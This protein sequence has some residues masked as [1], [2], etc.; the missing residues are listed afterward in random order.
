MKYSRKILKVSSNIKLEEASY[1]IKEISLKSNKQQQHD[2]NIEV[3]VIGELKQ[4]S[5]GHF[6]EVTI[7]WTC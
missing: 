3:S 4:Y 7:N 2:S 5:I 1:H 6:I